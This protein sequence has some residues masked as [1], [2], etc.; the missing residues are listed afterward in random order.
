MIRLEVYGK[1]L[2]V[3]YCQNFG[4]CIVNGKVEKFKYLLRIRYSQNFS[5]YVV[6]DS[7]NQI[8]KML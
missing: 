4:I 6:I 3:R 5:V 1:M 7:L 8:I 2:M